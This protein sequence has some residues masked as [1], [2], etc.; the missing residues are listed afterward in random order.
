MLIHA[1]FLFMGTNDLLGALDMAERY[2][3]ASILGLDLTP[4]PQSLYNNLQFQVDDI[5]QEWMPND[6][7]DLVHIRLLYGAIQDWPSLY[8]KIFE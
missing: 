4:P 8:S 2:P 7:Y 3:D 6:G 1:D 5:T